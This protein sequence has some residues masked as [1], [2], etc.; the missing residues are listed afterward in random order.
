MSDCKTCQELKDNPADAVFQDDGLWF[1]WDETG[2]QFLGP[3]DSEE[4]ARI[5]HIDYIKYHETGQYPEGLMPLSWSD[6]E[7]N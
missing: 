1:F 2:T 7:G 4:D 5:G 6:G 3:F